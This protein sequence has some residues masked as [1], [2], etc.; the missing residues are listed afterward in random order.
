MEGFDSHAMF[1]SMHP[2]DTVLRRTCLSIPTKG[3]P[4]PVL[5]MHDTSW[6]RPRC[7]YL[8]KVFI[9]FICCR[10]TYSPSPCQWKCGTQTVDLVSN[11]DLILMVFY[12]IAYVICT[13][14]SPLI[15][16]ALPQIW[17]Y[18]SISVRDSEI[19]N[20]SVL[21]LVLR[22]ILKTHLLAR[23]HGQSRH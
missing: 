7:Q 5:G 9:T 22:V 16:V 15:K 2:E 21:L 19:D 1:D 17:R 23:R 12:Q 11:L 14:R 13:G 10:N 6:L 3:R 8:A 20:Q 4:G 18:R